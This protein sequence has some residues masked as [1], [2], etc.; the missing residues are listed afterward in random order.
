MERRGVKTDIG[1]K[2]REIQERNN[3]REKLHVE[4]KAIIM[5]IEREKLSQNRQQVSKTPPQM[6]K[7]SP[8]ARAS[9]PQRIFYQ[10]TQRRRLDL[11]EGLK[12]QYGDQ[13]KV[14]QQELTQLFNSVSQSKG[15]Y[16]FWRNITGRT[17]K[18]KETISRLQVN[19]EKIQQKKQEA[20]AAFEKDRQNRL[21]MLKNKE[22]EKLTEKVPA[23]D[24]SKLEQAKLANEK[25]KM[26]QNTATRQ[27]G[28]EHER[29]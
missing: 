1:N 14:A 8:Q 12:R 13:E 15:I 4:Q 26:R 6:P 21:E 25:I 2:N 28:I 17:Q 10:E 23:N 24:F 18:D 3:E 20:F 16:G 7:I 19:L 9:D 5:E 29:D 22:Q 11:L 27:R